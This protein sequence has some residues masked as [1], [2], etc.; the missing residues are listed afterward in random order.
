[1]HDNEIL[2]AG[3]IAIGAIIF[4]VTVGSGVAIIVEHYRK[5]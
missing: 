1:M 4:L 5:R 3:I 2:I